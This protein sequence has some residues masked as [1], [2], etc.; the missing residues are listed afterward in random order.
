MGSYLDSDG[1]IRWEGAD[2]LL[3][4]RVTPGAS[5]EAFERETDW[6]RARIHARAREGQA[7]RQLI[8]SLGKL[9]GVPQADIILERGQTSRTKTVRVR[10]PA[11]LPSFVDAQD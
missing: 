6:I 7:N 5:T 11:R 4:I 9:F 10:S 8:K 3:T 1:G 2:L